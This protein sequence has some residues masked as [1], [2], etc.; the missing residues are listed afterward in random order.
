MPNNRSGLRFRHWSNKGYSL[1]A[2]INRAV[3]IGVVCA[4]ITDK[5]MLK[6][7]ISSAETETEAN[8]LGRWEG[9]LPPCAWQQANIL[10]PSQ[11]KD[12]D[13]TLEIAIDTNCSDTAHLVAMSESFYIIWIE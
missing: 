11:D 4:S 2:S 13:N 7:G 8:R 10:V 12:T 5:E 9:A 1:F 6:G 3:T